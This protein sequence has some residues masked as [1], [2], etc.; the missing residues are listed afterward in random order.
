M[1]VITDKNERRIVRDIRLLQ[2]F[3]I[4]HE[5]VRRQKRAASTDTDSFSSSF[6]EET[7]P[8][9]CTPAIKATCL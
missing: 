8:F 1:A 5:A 6:T 9:L 7:M 2:S 4:P 3:P